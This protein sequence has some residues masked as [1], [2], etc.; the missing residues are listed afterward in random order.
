MAQAPKTV[1]L[2]QLFTGAEIRRAQTLYRE[3]KG[4]GTFAATVAKELIEPNL[5]RINTATG[6]E[7]DPRYIAYMVEYAMAQAER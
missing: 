4:T 7:N 5:T 3:L 1:T 2:G 6:Q